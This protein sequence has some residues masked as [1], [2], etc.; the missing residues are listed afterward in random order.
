MHLVDTTLFYS[1]TSGGV[2]RYLNAKHA[3][4]KAHGNWR[5]SLVVPGAETRLVP[6]DV[7]TIRGSIVPGTFNYRLPLN[8]FEWSRA[9][10]AL[11]P[12]LIEAGDAFHPAWCAAG[13]ARRRGIPVVAFFHSHL[14]ALVGR[15]LGR[16]TAAAAGRYLRLIYE[17]MDVV[18]APSR[19]MC[20]HLRALG[21]RNVAL[22]PLGVDGEVFHPRR[23]GLDL[24]A[25]LGIPER[26]RLLVYA[27][28][29]SGEK[30]IPQ[31]EA[32]FELLGDD[33]HLLMIGGGEERRV[34]SNITR[35]PYRRDSA[36]LAGYLASADALVHAGTAETF[37]LVIVEAMACG[38]PVV[39]VR[40]GA[41]AE[42]VDD[43]IGRLAPS[44]D[45]A[46]LAQAV[47]DL[48]EQ[49][50]EALGRA[51]RER[52]ASRYTWSQALQQQVTLYANLCGVTPRVFAT[53]KVGPSAPQ[54]AF[55]E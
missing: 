15:R 20:D 44:A 50:L 28:R 6:D 41:V 34:A 17:R 13:V 51:A 53:P 33:Y 9:L 49:D 11:E 40:S 55:S 19:L 35:L 18:L 16:V 48:Y 37:G 54:P 39:G 30:N 1:P 26:T 43:H 3:W 29:F 21:L 7:S 22:Q 32:A 31:L 42:L 12:D 45:P 14:P 47:R 24:R 2:R 25:L 8:P 38:R 36:Q 4:L 27:G 5:H 52:V 23:R 46:H 10:E